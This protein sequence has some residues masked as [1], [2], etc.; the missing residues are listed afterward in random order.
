MR[1]PTFITHIF[2][3]LKIKLFLLP[4]LSALALLTLATAACGE[5]GSGSED[6][7]LPDKKLITG[8]KLIQVGW[9]QVATD[10]IRDHAAEM[11]KLPLDGL[12]FDVKFVNKQGK[13][14]FL[15]SSCFGKEEVPEAAVKKGIEDL[16]SSK[17]SR[18]TENFVRCNAQP[19]DID[20]FDNVAPI[21]HNVR[22]AARIVRATGTRGIFL[23]VEPYQ[24]HI[25]NHS[26]RPLKGQKYLAE[27]AE[28]VQKVANQIIVAIEEEA[29]GITIFLPFGYETAQAK[30]RPKDTYRYNLL[31]AFLDGLLEGA[32]TVDLVNGYEAAYGAMKEQDFTYAYNLMKG[33]ATVAKDPAKYRRIFSFGFGL[34]MDLE[35]NKKGWSVDNLDRNLFTPDKFQRAL[36]YAFKHSDRYVWIYTQ[37][38]RW[39]PPT[40]LPPEY[41]GAIRRARIASGLANPN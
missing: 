20:W 40:D 14:R 3:K 2:P 11:E 34:W 26:T 37:Q 27:Y 4:L 24:E 18:F 10:Y 12:V 6:N 35:S 15:S 13:N 38:P 21:L 16:H 25:F 5:H 30:A 8:K 29:P 1:L 19:G 36:I 9:G 32:I 33:D 28:Q 17:L 23:D 7:A 41:L 39:W 31:G 22:A